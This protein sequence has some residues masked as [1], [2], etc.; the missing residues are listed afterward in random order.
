MKFETDNWPL[1]PAKW[2][3]RITNGSRRV[4]V[5]VI[6]A[7]QN[8]ELDMSAENVGRWF[9]ITARPSSAHIG[10]DRDSIVQYVRDNDVAFA[11][12]GVNHDGIHVELAG[13]AQQSAEQWLDEYGIQMLDRAANAVAQYC[14]KY[15]LPCVKLTPQQLK[16]G[17]RGIIGHVDATQVYKPNAGHTDPGNG[18]P[19]QWFIP[20]AAEHIQ[21]LKGKLR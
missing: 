4:R 10:V 12:P 9:Q 18:F 6:H 19:W 8:Q 3:R 20:R 2:E 15:G 16:D 21:K 7:M 13:M 5:I 1:I 11:A 14:L 17:K